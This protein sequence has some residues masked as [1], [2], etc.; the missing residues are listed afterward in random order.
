MYIRRQVP[1]S[2]GFTN[3]W[4]LWTHASA[5]QQFLPAVMCGYKLLSTVNLQRRVMAIL[6]WGNSCQE[7]FSR[8]IRRCNSPGHNELQTPELLDVLAAPKSNNSSVRSD[9]TPCGQMYHTT[10][11][12]S[13]LGIGHTCLLSFFRHTASAKQRHTIRS[14]GNSIHNSSRTIIKY[15]V[16]GT[17]VPGTPRN[18]PMGQAT[19]DHFV[20]LE[21]VERLQLDPYL[22][23][24][25]FV[26][27]T[28][29][30]RSSRL[31]SS[32][33]RSIATTLACS[34]IHAHR[35]TSRGA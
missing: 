6:P 14:S 12:I 26:L 31:R 8:F 30:V 34:T 13:R 27:L 22:A 28:L 3:C 33:A 1:F 35:C 18:S 4:T 9:P 19:V 11:P 24:G 2:R 5:A 21:R 7:D 23:H 20:F 16:P 29:R 25:L 10:R 17:P 15:T 32:R